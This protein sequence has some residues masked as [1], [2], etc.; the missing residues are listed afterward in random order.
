MQRWLRSTLAATR[1]AVLPSRVRCAASLRTKQEDGFHDFPPTPSSIAGRC[2]WVCVHYLWRPNL[3]DEA[4]NH[5]PE[6][7]VAGGVQ[8][9][10]THNRR[11]FEHYELHF[12]QMR[13]VIPGELISEE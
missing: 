6:L 12:P 3:P 10:V 9:I 4:D 13:V 11:D 7:A 5:V 8:A 1:K 2:R